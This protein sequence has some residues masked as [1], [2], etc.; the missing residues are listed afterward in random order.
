MIV[1]FRRSWVMCS[2]GADQRSDLECGFPGWSSP[3][4][5]RWK[6]AIKKISDQ[7]RMDC[8]FLL[9][10]CSK[11][12]SL[13]PALSKVDIWENSIGELREAL[14]RLLQCSRRVRLR[15][16]MPTSLFLWSCE[17]LTPKGQNKLRSLSLQDRVIRAWM[18]GR[19]VKRMSN[20]D[21][22]FNFSFFLIFES[23]HLWVQIFQTQSFECSLYGILPQLTAW[24][25]IRQRDGCNQRRAWAELS[26][27]IEDLTWS[28]Q[29]GST[30]LLI[31]LFFFPLILNSIDLSHHQ[32]DDQPWPRFKRRELKEPRKRTLLDPSHSK[33]YKFHFQISVDFVS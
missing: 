25:S 1:T 22:S 23:F 24:S 15:S 26:G 9:T 32:S 10:F 30:N 3:T 29:A 12:S 8:F 17:K 2:I 27:K 4:F 28:T 6:G 14:F 19:R 18:K 7:N 20:D 13:P 21:F 11:S 16:L 33:S 5:L 31:L